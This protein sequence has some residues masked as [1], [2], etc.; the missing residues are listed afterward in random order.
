MRVSSSAR[1]AILLAAVVGFSGGDFAHRAFAA[2]PRFD[3]A[4]AAIQKAM[5]LLEAASTVGSPP[6]CDKKR[7]RSI[8]RLDAVQLLIG[9]T[10][11]CV[12]ES[13]L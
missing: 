6:K 7:L 3:E 2:D 4:Q 12:D 13:L 8:K 5:A 10:I 11:A 9:K 1:I